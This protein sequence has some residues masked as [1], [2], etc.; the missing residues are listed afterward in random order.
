MVD[1]GMRCALLAFLTWRSIG[2]ALAG[3][4]CAASFD[5]NASYGA[6]IAAVACAEHRLWFSPFLDDRGRLA[7]IT[8]AEAENIPLRDGLTP[9]WRRVADYWKGSGLI[10]QMPERAGA[11]ACTVPSPIPAQAAACR[12]FVVDTPWSATFVSF[13]MARAG[14][15]GFSMSASHIA[16]KGPGPT[17]TISI[18]LRPVSGPMDVLPGFDSN[19]TE[20]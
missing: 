4:P 7:S 17:P 14:L 1:W 13:V 3:D 5:A 12:I 15:P 9:G 11:D 2:T 19:P 18:S 8:V 10:W 6:R 16:A 20:R